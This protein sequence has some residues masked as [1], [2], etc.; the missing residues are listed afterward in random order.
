MSSR[1]AD[2]LI[3]LVVISVILIYFVG[4]NNYLNLLFATLKSIN[5]VLLQ[6]ENASILSFALKYYITFPIVGLILSYIGSPRGKKGHMV[7]KILYF[8]V[9]YIVCLI[10][11]FVAKLIF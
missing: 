2:A 8:L 4:L 11:D 3:N 9:G 5:E 7:G 6:L 10:L 1:K